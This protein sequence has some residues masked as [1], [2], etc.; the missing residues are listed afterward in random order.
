LLTALSLSKGKTRKRRV[1][2]SAATVAAEA[3]CEQ[4]AFS[5]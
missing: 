2:A 3:D 5:L 1:E 4:A